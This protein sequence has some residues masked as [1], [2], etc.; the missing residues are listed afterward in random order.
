MRIFLGLIAT[1]VG[2][3]ITWKANWIVNNFGRVPWAEKWLGIEGGSRLF[4]KLMGVLIVVIGWL[5]MIGATEK[6]ILWIFSPALPR[7]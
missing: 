6:I 3:I 5:Y 4:W 1:V 7:Q 2:F